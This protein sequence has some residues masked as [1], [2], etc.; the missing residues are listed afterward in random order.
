[1]DKSCIEL[2]LTIFRAPRTMAYDVQGP[3]T[4]TMLSLDI[5][6]FACPIHASAMH[7]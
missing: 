6:F 5:R 4:N 1:M 2:L 7:A 3:L